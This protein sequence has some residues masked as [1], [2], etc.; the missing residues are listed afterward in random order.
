MH[1]S[2]T[3][4]STTYSNFVTARKPQSLAAAPRVTLIVLTWNQRELTLACLA[5][6]LQLQ[7]DNYQIIV[8]DNGSRDST[9]AAIRQKFP[10]VIVIENRENLGFAEGNNAGIRMALADKADYVMLLN[11]DTIADPLML[12]ELIAV[13]ESNAQ[14][15]IVGPAIYS[16]HEPRDIWSAG[17]RIAW[18]N[19]SVGRLLESDIPSP[20]Q[21]SFEVDY[22][23]G[24]ALC[25]KREVI[26]RIGLLDPR[27]FIYFEDTDWCLRARACG[28]ASAVVPAARL[29]HHVSA[30]TGENSPVTDYYMVRNS[31]LMVAKNLSGLERVRVLVGTAL[32][33]S[34]AIAAFT[35]KRRHRARRLNRN[36][37]LLGMRDALRGRW[38]RMGQ[39]VAV[40]LTADSNLLKK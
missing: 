30:T 7:Y 16:T 38:G 26:E 37:K 27:Y 28:Y 32:L 18:H 19:A 14:I 12:Q 21:A 24:C 9:A 13:A 2:A 5:S 39:D 40:R 31:F 22:V 3:M 4:S 23:T 34:R 29:W 15:G 8:V 36:A 6:L 11:D 20:R 33:H 1:F 35:L 10:G 17:N 25:I